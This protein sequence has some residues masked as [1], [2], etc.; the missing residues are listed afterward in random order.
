ML[1]DAFSR[2]IRRRDAAGRILRAA[3]LPTFLAAALSWL[4]VS[5]RPR[6]S[7]RRAESTGRIESGVDATIKP[8][9]DFFAYANGAWLK[10]TRDSRRQG[11]LGRP[12]RDRRAD[13]PARRAS[14]STTRAP[15]RRDRPRARWP[16]FAR[17]SS[18]RP[19]SR[20]RA[21]RRSSRCSTASIAF[22]TR[23]RSLALLGRGMRADVDPLNWGVYQS[24]HLLG[25]SVEPSIHGEKN[26]RRLPGAG[27]ARPARPREL[28]QR[29]APHAGAAHQV[30]GVHRPHCWHWPASTARTQRA[31][32]GDGAGDRHRAEPG[33]ARSI[34]ERSQRRQR[35][36]ARRTSRARRRA[37]TG[38]QF[39]AAAGL[40]KQENFVAW[41]PTAV[42][43]VAALVASQPLEAWKDY[44]RFH[45]ARSLRR[46][47]AAC[48]RRAGAGDAW[49][50]RRPG[51]HRPPPRA[52][53]ALEATQSA[54]SDAIGRMYAERY[55]P[56]EQKARV[57]A[58]VANVTAAFVRRVEAA[59]WM[60]P[61]Y[62]ARSRWR[63]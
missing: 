39:F 43:G 51:R 60:S 32:G 47:A 12:R 62:E 31:A 26:I 38:P 57:Q 25:L 40:A 56:A 9:D 42:T 18:T 48:I 41:Q 3:L 15:H 54:M 6:A 35:V 13:P 30:P 11:T 24:S 50:R 61:S 22:T 23:R 5:S 27:R 16:I 36:D 1:I 29:R 63:S 4:P 34:G 8:G 45:V 52:Q 28:R 20:P 58:I 21:S 7:S 37:W 17:P 10:A 49:P 44:L 14:C 55:F 19:P 33:H 53:R 46:R 59:T 2:G